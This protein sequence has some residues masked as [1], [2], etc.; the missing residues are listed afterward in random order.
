MLVSRRS[1][2]AV[3]CA[4][5][6]L[7]GLLPADAA[8]HN[9]QWCGPSVHGMAR[10]PPLRTRASVTASVTGRCNTSVASRFFLNSRTGPW[11][12]DAQ[13]AQRRLRHLGHLSPLSETAWAK[14]LLFAQPST[15]NRAWGRP[16][17]W[18]GARS[19]LADLGLEAS[20]YH[21]AQCRSGW[22]SF[23]AR[24]NP[25]AGWRSPRQ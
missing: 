9:L 24:V 8:A 12:L 23:A 25:A 15:G 1:H 14:H 16:E 18:D 19:T 20:W 13:L 6:E 7:V 21:H 10:S 11:P 4:A 17:C 3:G 2:V 5:A 22:R